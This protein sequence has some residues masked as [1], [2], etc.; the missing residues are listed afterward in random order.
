MDAVTTVA[1]P[2]T[3]GDVMTTF[4]LHIH[5]DNAAFTDK[6]NIYADHLEV[7]RILRGVAQGLEEGFD[8]SHYKTLF[9]INGN[10]VG[11]AAFKAS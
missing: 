3:V 10:D 11:R 8:F 4:K 6:D 9:D 5:T 1:Q 2:L 7:A